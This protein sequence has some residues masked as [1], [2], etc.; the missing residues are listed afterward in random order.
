MIPFQ[1]D[2]EIAQRF[3]GLNI[4]FLEGTCEKNA[5]VDPAGFFELKTKAEA[6]ARKIP[7]LSEHPHIAA[8][9]KTFKSFKADPSKTKP[10]V[11]ALVR[12]IQKGESLPS[13]NPI[14]DVYNAVS[15]AHVL[16]IGG[17]DAEKIQGSVT[18][19]FSRPDDTFTP[20]GANERQ[21]VDD[22]EVVYADEKKVLCSKWNWRDCFDARI[23]D[24]TRKFVL[25]VDGCPS[26]PR[27]TV[28]N[29][30]Q[31]LSEN[32]EKFVQGC[33]TEKYLV[34]PPRDSNNVSA[35]K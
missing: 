13:I 26:I 33:R 7:I 2:P 32:L 30:L 12:R 35:E 18:L 6:A 28:E 9:R 10:S 17:Q 1:I 15:L 34:A 23:T 31:A 27:E 16:P 5:C 14:V 22:K 4:G 25:F 19:R 20:L 3:A 29:A 8:W 11:E 24:Q 21:K